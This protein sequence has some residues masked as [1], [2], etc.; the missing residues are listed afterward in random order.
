MANYTQTELK[1]K[2]LHQQLLKL[3]LWELADGFS[4][5][6]YKYGGE[7]YKQGIAM[8]NEINNQ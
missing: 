2:E 3:Q 8:V 7:N 1:F 6:F 5:V 4:S